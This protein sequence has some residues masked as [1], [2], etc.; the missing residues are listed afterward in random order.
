MPLSKYLMESDEEA[1]RLDLKT[2]VS[3]VKKQAIWAGLK[4]GMRVADLGCGP[5]KTTFCLNQLANPMAQTMGIDISKNRIEYAKKNYFEPEIEYLQ[6]DIRL[7]LD[8]LGMFDFV[9]IRF[10]LEYYLSN[11][12]EIVKN[13]SRIVKPGGILCLVDL[14]C[15]CLRHHGFSLRFEKAVNGIMDD[16]ATNYNFDPYAGVK[17]YSYLFDLGY[18]EI[19]ADVSAHNLICGSISDSRLFNWQ[20]KVQI[21]GKKSGFKFTGYRRGYEG[22]AQEFKESISN[23]RVFYYSPLIVCRG[24]KPNL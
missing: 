10:V 4:S 12:F 20:K 3:E 6:G 7:P 24:K 16:L 14:D 15:N 5:G 23:P 19:S 21:A 8:H 18:E 11:S 1:L 2:N 17:L 9:W 13:I 22:F